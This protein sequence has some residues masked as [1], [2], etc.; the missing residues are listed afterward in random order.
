RQVDHGAVQMSKASRMSTAAAIAAFLVPAAALASPIAFDTSPDAPAR[1]IVNVVFAQYLQERIGASVE[2]AVLDLDNDGT[3]EI[4]VRFVHTASCA[5]GLK[6]CRTALISHE[7]GDWKIVFDRYAETLEFRPH[8]GRIPGPIIAD[9][10]PW[11]WSRGHA[12]A[13]DGS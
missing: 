8:D 1:R 11:K 6:K 12:Y 13:P 10:V 9:G 4:A 7:R 3:G 5:E 2:T